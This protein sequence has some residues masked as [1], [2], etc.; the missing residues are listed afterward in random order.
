MGV[1]NHLLTGMILQVV[2]PYLP[3]LRPYWSPLLVTL[4]GHP[5]G[6]PLDPGQISPTVSSNNVSEKVKNL[7]NR[8]MPQNMIHESL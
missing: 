3:S 4:I 6:L 2:S 7:T 1:T 5:K 8:A